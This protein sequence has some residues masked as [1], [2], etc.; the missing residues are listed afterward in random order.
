MSAEQTAAGIESAAIGRARHRRRRDDAGI[1]DRRRRRGRRQRGYCDRRGLVP[2]AVGNDGGDRIGSGGLRRIGCRRAASRRPRP[3]ADPMAR[4]WRPEL[5]ARSADR[6]AALRCRRR[7]RRPDT[8]VPSGR[9]VTVRTLRLASPRFG[10]RR[11]SARHDAG[12]VGDAG[13]S[14]LVASRP[15][16]RRCRLRQRRRS[17][18]RPRTL[19]VPPCRRRPAPGPA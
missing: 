12:H 6:P 15:A 2:S 5:P 14:S 10:R 1:E 16:S 8:M 17:R 18:R 9:T 4:R 3:S 11:P 13:A 7:R 19:R